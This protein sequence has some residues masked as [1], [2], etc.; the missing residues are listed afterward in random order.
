MTVHPVIAAVP[1]LVTVRDAVNPVPQ[2]V[3]TLYAALHDVVAAAAAAGGRP[4]GL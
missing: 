2:S 4:A 3:C 1:L